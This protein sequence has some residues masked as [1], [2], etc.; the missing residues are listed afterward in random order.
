MAVTRQEFEAFL[1]CPLKSHLLAHGEPAPG[2]PL[3]KARTELDGTFQEHGVA[4]LLNVIPA[5]AVS[6]DGPPT[7]ALKEHLFHF[8]LDWLIATPSVKSR[9]HGAELIRS[10]ES[11]KRQR[12]RLSGY[13]PTK[14]CPRKRS[15]R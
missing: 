7:G 9:Q 14:L 6:V 13:F 12:M 4:N 3:T 1:V 5:S 11:D 2:T 8:I 15:C 10:R